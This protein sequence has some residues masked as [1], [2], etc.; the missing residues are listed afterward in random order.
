MGRKT[1][2]EDRDTVKLKDILMAFNRRRWLF[3]GFPRLPHFFKKIPPYK[4]FS[5]FLWHYIDF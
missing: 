4:G 3:A 5:D 1:G 2:N